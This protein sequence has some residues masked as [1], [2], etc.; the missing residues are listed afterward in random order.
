MPPLAAS[1]WRGV[2]GG[3]VDLTPLYNGASSP[4]GVGMG[5]CTQERMVFAIAVR[6]IV[7]ATWAQS[8]LRL[9]VWDPRDHYCHSSS[10]ELLR[11]AKWVLDAP[12]MQ[13][14]HRLRP[15]PHNALCNLLWPVGFEHGAAD[16]LLI[17]YH[18]ALLDDSVSIEALCGALPRYSSCNDELRLSACALHLV[19]GIS[20]A[21]PQHVPFKPV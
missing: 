19:L 8:G 12:N 7:T 18:H 17:H 2:E 20:N 4:H 13:R 6:L 1:I 10:I 15:A 11:V 21:V 3:A 16:I 5:H 14:S 9:L